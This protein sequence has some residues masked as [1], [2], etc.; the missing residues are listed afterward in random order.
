M[1]LL[2]SP[3]CLM[4]TSTLLPIS[5]LMTMS[6]EQIEGLSPEQYS[7]FLADGE[8]CNTPYTIAPHSV[9]NYTYESEI[10]SRITWV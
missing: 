9:V 5:T 6:Q 3:F 10:H 8:F 7:L 1:T 2:K 4:T